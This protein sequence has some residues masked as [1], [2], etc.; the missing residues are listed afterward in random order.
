MGAQYAATPVG[1]EAWVRLL[2]EG[3]VEDLDAGTW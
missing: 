2:G 3:G 1:S